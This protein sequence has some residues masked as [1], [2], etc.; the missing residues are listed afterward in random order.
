[1]VAKSLKC[2]PECVMLVCDRSIS[3]P[4]ELANISGD[5]VIP[6]DGV[7]MTYLGGGNF[8]K[9]LMQLPPPSPTDSK[10]VSIKFG[11]NRGYY[12]TITGATT[13][14]EVLLLLH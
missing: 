2:P 10:V 6:S 7:V 1:M 11:H 8:I 5:R 13:T 3:A 4:P 14:N 12:F 9:C